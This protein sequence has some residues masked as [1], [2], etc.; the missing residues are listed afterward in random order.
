MK[1]DRR[2]LLPRIWAGVGIAVGVSLLFGAL[3]TF[4]PRG[5]TFEAKEL[6]GGLLSVV[7]VGF[8]TRMIFW[9]AGAARSLSG[10]LRS[11]ID[12]AA[13]AK[14]WSLVVVAMFAVGREE[15][16]TALFIWAAT[17]AA[18]L[19]RSAGIDRNCDRHHLRG[20]DQHRTVGES[21][22]QRDQQR[23]QGQ[24]VLSGPERLGAPVGCRHGERATALAFVRL[25]WSL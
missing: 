2:H 16:E 1:S 22:V 24:R 5:L 23:Q 15:L 25:G 12:D 10:E 7:A 9:M 3:L 17:E 11:R 6:I 13:E 20:I 8:V 21:A 4:G 19:G 14:P 18:T